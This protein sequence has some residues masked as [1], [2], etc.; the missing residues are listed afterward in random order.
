MYT[1]SPIFSHAQ[2]PET[3]YHKLAVLFSV[4]AIGSLFD[5]TLEP[6]S[7]KAN[8]YFHASRTALSFL[9]PYRST[10]L[11]SIQAIVSIDA[12]MEVVAN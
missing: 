12:K 1:H 10:T 4:F 3:W 9:A 6:F 11:A 5:P 8:D 2:V 7:T